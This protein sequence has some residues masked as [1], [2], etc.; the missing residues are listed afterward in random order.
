MTFK[1]R[2]INR[3][4][5]KENQ[6]KFKKIIMENIIHNTLEGGGRI[7]ETKENYQKFVVPIVCSK[8]GSVCFIRT[9]VFD[10]TQIEGPACED[11]SSL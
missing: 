7:S 2:V 8:G 3:D 10:D 4:I 11:S 9:L 6:H 5:V 1:R